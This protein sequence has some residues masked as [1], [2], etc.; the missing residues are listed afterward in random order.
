MG[1]GVIPDFRGDC[2]CHHDGVH[3]RV[4]RNRFHGLHHHR[5]VVA[6]AGR[7]IKGV[8]HGA[9]VRNQG[10]KVRLCLLLHFRQ[11]DAVFLG[12]VGHDAGLAAGH[13]HEHAAFPLW[14]FFQP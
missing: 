9:I 3:A 4:L 1:N 7:H 5:R 11:L 12:Q 14:Q 8:V 13:V 10:L 6:D 2:I